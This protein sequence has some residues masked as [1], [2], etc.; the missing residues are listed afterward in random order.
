MAF[1]ST[2][3]RDFFYVLELDSSVISYDE[4]PFQVLIEWNGA[5][6]RY[7]PDVL[8]DRS[9]TSIPLIV[10]IKPSIEDFPVEKRKAMEFWC[11]KSGFEFEVIDALGIRTAELER[12]KFLYPYL[13]N[14][15]TQEMYELILEQIS[16]STTA[17]VKELIQSSNSRLADIYYLIATGILNCTGVPSINSVI[18]IAER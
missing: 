6:Y 15:P 13:R 11:S 8:V 12:A 2:F 4:Q 3:E 16:K 14:S 18:S 7:T 17:P 9:C 10:E 5:P 1:E